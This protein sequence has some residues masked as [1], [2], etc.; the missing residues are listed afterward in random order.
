MKY[1]LV[2]GRT[3][4]RKSRCVLCAVPIG[5]GGYLRDIRTRLCYCGAECHALQ[6]AETAILPENQAKAS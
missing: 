5:E 2:N 6:S 1:V 3:P 4:F